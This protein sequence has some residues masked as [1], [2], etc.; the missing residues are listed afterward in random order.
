VQD[1]NIALAK[2]VAQL[3]ADE[4]QFDYVRFPAEGDQKD[5]SFVFQKDQPEPNQW[6]RHRPMPE[7]V[8]TGASPVPPN[9]K[10]SGTSTTAEKPPEARQP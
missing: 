6:R 7:H 3:G 1:Y 8:A 4:I 10:P 9:A 5:A 2:Y